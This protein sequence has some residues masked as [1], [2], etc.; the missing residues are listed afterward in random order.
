MIAVGD[1]VDDH[2]G[3]RLGKITAIIQQEAGRYLHIRDPKSGKRTIIF[4]PRDGR[5][6][7][8]EQEDV[9][10]LKSWLDAGAKLH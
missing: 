10:Q 5:S 1:W 6:F 4:V 8:L 9:H 7:E 2:E 3:K